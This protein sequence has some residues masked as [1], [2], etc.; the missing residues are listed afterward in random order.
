MEKGPRRIVHSVPEEILKDE[1]LGRAIGELLPSNYNFEI[2]KTVWRIRQAK[3][4]TVALQLPEGLQ[5]F[6]CPLA[7]IFQRFCA[8]D[9]IILGDV[10][11]GACCIDDLTARALGAELLVHYG[12]SCLV[13]IDT[14][15]MPVLYVFVEIEI[16]SDH[17]LRSILHNFESSQRLLLVS[18][19]QFVGS[20][21]KIRPQLQ[22]HYQS[23]EVPQARPLSKGEVLGCTAPQVKAEEVDAM[24]YVGDGRFHLEAMM[25]ANPSI[26]AFRYDPYSKVMSA[27]AYSHEQMR[28]NRKK[29]IE[30]AAM[31][32]SI[33]II[34]G[35]LGRQGNPNILTHIKAS[36]EAAGKHYLVI[37]LSEIT[38]AKLAM[39]QDVGAWVQVAC[40]RLS[41]D[42]G[43][44][45][46]VPLLSSYELQVALK[47]AEWQ[48]VYPMD[49]YAQ[50]AGSW[51]NY[52]NN[53]RAKERRQAEEARSSGTDLKRADQLKS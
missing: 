23:I 6:A 21:H 44:L 3:V 36:L 49:F 7:D 39:F 43:H 10:T 8:V 9:V 14:C 24:I 27:E 51:G 2:H 35:T 25:I 29:A 40:P 32:S 47:T 42:W 38:P 53:Q 46:H 4:G 33:G 15:V 48:E 16:D 20:L 28:Y 18:T 1:E 30:E 52:P 26:P 34:L 11:Y 5:M 12:H 22:E 31:A 13:P 45:F 50:T 37:L 19:I 17:L 41:I